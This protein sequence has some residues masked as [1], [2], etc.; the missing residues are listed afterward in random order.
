MR[1][2]YTTRYASP[3]GDM[4]LAAD[5]IG[6]TGVWFDGQK[7]FA[8]SLDTNCTEKET[9]DLVYAKRWLDA[10]FHGIQPNFMPRL[11]LTGS[12]FQ[13]TVWQVLLQIP[14]GQTTTYGAIAKQIACERGLPHM[15]AQAVGGAVGHNP[16]SILVPCHRVVGTNGKLT[17]YAG[18]MERKRQLI[19]WEKKY[20][21]AA[22]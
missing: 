6:L 21:L 10:Y 16:I 3:L 13:Q 15:S 9:T 14:Y 19:L 11:H 18:G 1:M 12:A 7:Y 22:E 5:E 20:A 17:G 8:R 4:L 2:M